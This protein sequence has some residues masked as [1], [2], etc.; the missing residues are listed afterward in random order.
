MPNKRISE[1]EERTFLK[2]NCAEQILLE[3]NPSFESNLEKNENIFFLLAR[4]KVKNENINYPTL[5]TSVL[6]GSLCD[7]GSQTIS[8]EKTFADNFSIGE[9][10]SRKET[11]EQSCIIDGYIKKLNKENININLTENTTF[12]NSAKTINLSTLDGRVSFS[13]SGC[14][15]ICATE[16]NGSLSVGG[17]AFIQNIYI[18]SVN[19]RFYKLMH[20]PT[21]LDYTF[22]DDET[23]CFKYKLNKGTDNFTIQFPKVFKERPIL[24]LTLQKPSMSKI[25]FIV[26]AVNQHKFSIEL[27]TNIDEEETFLHVTAASPSWLETDEIGIVENPEANQR[28]LTKITTTTKR[29]TI[30][31]PF[32]HKN[33]P[34]ISTTLEGSNNIVSYTISSV[35]N[36][37]YDIIFD[38]PVNQDFSV[39]TF[40]QETS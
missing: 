15:N 2:S 30:T 39:H 18:E 9:K 7:H 23:I 17:Q 11:D 13:D 22:H 33:T 38:S 35:N 37:S 1:L 29:Q 8:E 25:P 10:G 26:S 28:F 16:D 31:F 20:D 6:D 4:E 32:P 21:E 40:T 3:E 5:K 27:G 14:F 34:V 36:T 12:I 24:S 19:K